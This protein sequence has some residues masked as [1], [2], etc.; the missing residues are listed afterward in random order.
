[1]TDLRETIARAVAAELGRQDDET[2]WK[3]ADDLKVAYLD[4]GEVDFGKVADAVIAVL[5][6]ETKLAVVKPLNLGPSVSTGKRTP[7]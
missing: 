7:V 2:P 5:P 3:L 1:M 6:E 4:Q